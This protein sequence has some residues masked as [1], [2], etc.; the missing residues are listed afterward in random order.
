MTLPLKWK[1]PGGKVEVNE[2][3][4]ERF[5]REIIEGLNLNI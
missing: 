1:F 3:Y 5:K 2:F 4:E